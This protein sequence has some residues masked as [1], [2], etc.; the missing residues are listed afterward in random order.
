MERLSDV[1][2]CGSDFV[3]MSNISSKCKFKIKR[4]TRPISVT[5]QVNGYVET[6]DRFFKKKK[7]ISQR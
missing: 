2:W 6:V 7:I 4:S 5:V 3:W 1:T